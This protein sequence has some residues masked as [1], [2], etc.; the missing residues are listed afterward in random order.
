MFKSVLNTLRAF[1]SMKVKI[2]TK[3]SEI[4]WDRLKELFRK[5]NQ[6]SHLSIECFDPRL[7]TTSSIRSVLLQLSPYSLEE[8]NISNVA[9]LDSLSAFFR[10]QNAIISL[11][12]NGVVG[13]VNSLN[14]LQLTILKLRGPKSKHLGDLLRSQKGLKTLKISIDKETTYN[15]QVFA[16]IVKLNKLESLDVPLSENLSFDVIKSLE[17][18]KN[19]KK[20]SVSCS[21]T[22]LPNLVEISIPSLQEL[23]ITLDSPGLINSI[24]LL[25]QN[26]PNLHSLK[27]HGPLVIN[28]LTEIAT[29]YPNLESLWL[30]NDESFFVNVLSLSSPTTP[31]LK[32]KHL[33]II[34]RD[35]KFV[36][37][38]NNLIKFLKSFKSLETLVISKNI[39][40]QVNNFEAILLHLPALKEIVIN[41]NC[42]VSTTAAM[43]VVKSHGENL[44]YVQLEHYKLE[45]EIASLK[46]FFGGKFQTIEKKEGNLTLKN[47][48]EKLLYR[49]IYEK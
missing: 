45:A 40:I 41:A 38:A 3:M 30:E 7:A 13:D 14:N 29:F 24:D 27:L 6:T 19:L 35:K 2:T 47:G 49:K 48:R 22:G 10:Q 25:S 36:I 28:F 44:N 12:I 33:R 8:L 1:N 21:V 20:L 31:R 18:L 39:D 37:C 11:L 32:L 43:N 15:D 46:V 42:F 23:D 34:N 16:E 9:N 26:I 5:Y 17:K 4:C